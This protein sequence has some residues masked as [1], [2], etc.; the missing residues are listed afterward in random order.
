MAEEIGKTYQS[1]N[2][3]GTNLSLSNNIST[4][5]KPTLANTIL[6]VPTAIIQLLLCFKLG[7]NLL[8][9]NG[10]SKLHFKLH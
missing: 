8:R 6:K 7:D 9:R 2:Q 3:N 5:Q 10:Y 1:K 4:K